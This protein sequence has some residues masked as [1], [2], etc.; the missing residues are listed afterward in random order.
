MEAERVGEDLSQSVL[1]SGVSQISFGSEDVGGPPVRARI[2]ERQAPTDCGS[3][4][5]RGQNE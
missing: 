2:I 5:A 4:M 1:Q 3:V